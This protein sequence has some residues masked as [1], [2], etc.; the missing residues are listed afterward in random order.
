MYKRHRPDKAR[1]YA[2]AESQQGLFTTKQVKTCGYA[3]NTHPYHVR[4]GH[5]IRE[6]R[7][8]YRLALFPVSEEEQ[9]VLW[10]LWS[11]NRKEEPQGVYSHAT[12]LSIHDFTDVMPEKLHL[13]VTKSFRRFHEPPAV[14]VLHKAVLAE[15]EVE[16]RHGYA[17]TTPLRTLFDVATD[18]SIPDGLLEQAVRDALRT[19]LVPR[20]QLKKHAA[21]YPERLRRIVDT[22]TA[23]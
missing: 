8:I 11:M 4:Q 12:A 19:G 15:N 10:S 7:G 20:A 5:W 1:L 17:V 14:L 9:L 18:E 3:E 6:R 2:I 21:A 13:T 23:Q 22:E 16:L